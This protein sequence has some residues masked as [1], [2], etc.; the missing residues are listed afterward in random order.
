MKK[1]LL[2]I[3]LLVCAITAHAS[4]L[5]PAL[6]LDNIKQIKT[7]E[8][9][10]DELYWVIT[11]FKS[12]GKNKQYTIPRYPVHWPSKA[13]DQIKKLTLWN[14]ELKDGQSVILYVELVEHD[15]PPFNVDDSIGSVRL[16]IKNRK[17]RLK[18]DWQD[19]E[20]VKR[21][22][23]KKNK[24]QELTFHGEGA[25]YVAELQFKQLKAKDYK[26]LKHQGHHKT[27]MLR[28]K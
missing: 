10:G 1:G 18:V 9:Y 13:L 21:K 6:V 15:A 28:G 5:Y 2:A 24:G 3:F 25:E 7:V 17:N 20:N 11:E 27:R 26:P 8:N 16:V 23:L 14:S 12:N 4:T 19:S 22:I